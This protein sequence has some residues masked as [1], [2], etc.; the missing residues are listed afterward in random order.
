MSRG[1]GALTHT[2]TMKTKQLTEDQHKEIARWVTS[3]AHTTH[4][5]VLIP[6]TY[7]KTSKAGR[8]ANKAYDALSKLRAEMDN[9][10]VSDVPTDDAIRIYYPG[11]STNSAKPEILP[12]PF[13]GGA[14][15]HTPFIQGPIEHGI[16]SYWPECVECPAC[17]IIVRRGTNGVTDPVDHWN[18]R[19][20]TP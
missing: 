15:R 9:R 6:T 8:L 10:C 11:S 16:G 2:N 3:P 12:C 17:N 14:P 5:A 4:L 19:S 13:C 1:R 7:G 18:T 20:T